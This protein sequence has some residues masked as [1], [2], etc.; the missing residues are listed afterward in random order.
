V[1][2][3]EI[4]SVARSGGR[5]SAFRAK[6]GSRLTRSDVVAAAGRLLDEQGVEGL[7]MR[8]LAGALGTGPS[9]LYWHVRDKQQLLALIL[10]DTIA[11]VAAPAGGSWRERLVALLDDARQVLVSRPMLVPVILGARWEV[12]HHGL[13]I[14]DTVLGLLAEGGTPDDE[15][16]EA[17]FLL[18]H[19]TMGSVEAE[20]YARWNATYAEEAAG[21]EH[22]PVDGQ[23]LD[24]YPRL[25]RYGPATAP[26]DMPNRFRF[27]L[28]TIL[29]GLTE[30][31]SR[32]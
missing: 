17:Y 32:R 26:D 10:D 29:D 5:S 16:A 11:S 15:M 23:A 13:R 31:R 2:R 7:S 24:Q 9:T 19:Y 8:R 12:G 22:S 18:L 1:S 30:R 3:T 28:N 20:A 4:E 25:L 21:Q 14:A 6:G 27:G